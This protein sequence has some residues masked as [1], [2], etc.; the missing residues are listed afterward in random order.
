MNEAEQRGYEV[1]IAETEEALRA[2][3]PVM[4]RIY[5]AKTWDKALNRA[6]VE[7]SSEL[8]RLENVFYPE[9]IHLSD[10]PTPQAETIPSTVNPNEEVLPPSLPPPD[11]PDPTKEDTTPPEASSDKTAAA[12]EAEVASP[13]FQQD[14]ASTILPAGGAT[15]DKGEVTTAEVDKP[16]SQAPKIQ[17]KLKK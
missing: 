4:C 1:G 9:A 11:Q 7:V 16:A 10:T 6:G 15:K 3:V 12:S 2:E 14:L 5:Y 13:N 8:R 17:I